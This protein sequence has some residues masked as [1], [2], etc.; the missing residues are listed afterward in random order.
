MDALTLIA[1]NFARVCIGAFEGL[2]FALVDIPAGFIA[3]NVALANGIVLAAIGFLP[4]AGIALFAGI[5]GFVAAIIGV[6]DYITTLLTYPI[7]VTLAFFNGVILALIL[8]FIGW[9]VGYIFH[10]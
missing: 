8:G 4:N 7:Q 5:N 6:I 9:V 3:G 2:W 1:V 10:P